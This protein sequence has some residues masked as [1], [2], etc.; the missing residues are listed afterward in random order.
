MNATMTTTVTHQPMR[1]TRGVVHVGHVASDESR[2]GP[3][4]AEAYEI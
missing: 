1:G 2:V 3:I 4:P